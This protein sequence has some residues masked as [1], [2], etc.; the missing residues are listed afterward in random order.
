M[1]SITLYVT[2]FIASSAMGLLETA[3]DGDGKN[4]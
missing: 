3:V 1:K 4:S 2:G